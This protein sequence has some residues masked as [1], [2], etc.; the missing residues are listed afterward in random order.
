M[1]RIFSNPERHAPP[2]SGFFHAASAISV[3]ATG[4]AAASSA[5]AHTAATDGTTTSDETQAGGSTGVGEVVVTGIRP[6]LGDKI[7]LQVKD[8]PQ[9]VNVVPQKLLQ[10]QAVTRLEDALKNVPGV[11]LNAG[12]G[13]ARGD[14]INIRGFSAF[15][16]FFLDGIRDAA[17]YVRDPFNLD[18]I[19]VLKG[20]SATL[21]GRGSTGGAVNQ[22]SK[23]PSLTPFGVLTADY[24]TN[25]EFRG[26]LDVNEPL[27]SGV[28]FRL[29]AMGE[30][31]HV[32]ERQYVDNKHWGVAP[33]LSFGLG[34][35]TTATL[36]YFHLSEHDIPDSGVPFI[37]GAPANVPRQNYY[38]LASDRAVSDVNIGTFR[39]R[40]ELSPNI[41][42]SNTFRYANY[43][44]DYQFDA[45]NF[46]SV[47]SG[48]LGPPGPGTPL[49]DILVGR[50]SPSSSGTQTNLTDQGDLTARFRTGILSHTLVAGFEVARQT[51]D[52]DR[53][54]NPFDSNNNWVP[55]TPLLHPN[56]NEA[57]P[58]EPVTSTQDTT[59]NSQAGYLTDTIGVGSRLDLIA[60]VRLDRFAASYVQHT[61]TT[62][63]V[64]NLNHTDVVA[65]PRFAV[66]FKPTS[67]QSLY[68]S[69]GTSFDPSAEALT[70]TTKLADLGPVKATTFEV[71]TKSSLFDGGLLLTGAAFHTEVD[72]AQINDPDNP[73]L[74]VLQGNQ[75]VQGFELGA[76]GHIT[77]KLE[78]TAGYTYLDGKASGAVGSNP[79]IEY[80]DALIPNVA[81][82][83]ANVWI[84]YYV[85]DPWEVGIGFNYLD[86][87][88]GNIV[89]P[90][91]TPAV[92]P[93]YTVVSAMTS[94]R[95]NERLSVQLNL[96]NLANTLYYDNIYY[97]SASENHVIPGAG[98]TFKVTLRASF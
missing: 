94:Y 40:H 82:N 79:V 63:A 32:A 11:T 74:T 2:F 3:C 28:A 34:S 47:A 64:L 69:Y 18:S 96:I 50:D 53:Y 6:L 4:I 42:V 22:V 78:I 41:S 97:T 80:A 17:I 26:A 91:V 87:R 27:G 39:L 71:G 35:P 51:N 23:A 36:A 52:L 60:G 14:T 90:G 16:D 54:A 8:T 19:E 44:F 37:N 55:E 59:A 15:N 95:V 68:F 62:G 7:P 57:R 13:A 86:H 25:D 89:T 45:P 65:S 70:L 30:S 77:S 5:L 20:P 76:N 85:T 38:G 92:V 73:G 66:V 1:M 12:E 83:A 33:E 10:E 21:F 31:S 48:G 43:S 56:P 84:E 9:S 29:N 98:R 67:W 93:S 75:T 88:L 49:S 58:N 72:N 61:L 46:G 81:R 24:G